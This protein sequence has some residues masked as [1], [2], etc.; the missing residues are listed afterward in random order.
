MS[1]SVFLVSC[2]HCKRPVATVARLDDPEL[3]RLRTH[4]RACRPAERLD[5]LDMEAT[6]RHFRVTATE[7]E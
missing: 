6:L 7:P 4:L 2:K 1:A 5:D 3:A